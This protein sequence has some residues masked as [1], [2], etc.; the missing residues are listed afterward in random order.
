MLFPQALW[1]ELWQCGKESWQERVGTGEIL[2]TAEQLL[3]LPF[4]E[5]LA[6]S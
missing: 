2:L 3:S 6:L 1:E 5:F 4:S